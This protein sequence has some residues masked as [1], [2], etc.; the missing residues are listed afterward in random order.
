MIDTAVFD[1]E[2]ADLLFRAPG[3]HKDQRN[4]TLLD[5]DRDLR[6]LREE[7][8]AAATDD[9]IVNLDGELDTFR[10]AVDQGQRAQ[11]AWRQGHAGGGGFGWPMIGLLILALAYRRQL[12]AA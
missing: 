7:G 5:S 10:A 12:R 1:V 3:V 6:M 11:V 8:F 9:M 2:T 4:V